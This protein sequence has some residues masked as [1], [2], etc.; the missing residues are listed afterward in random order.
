MPSECKNGLDEW[1]RITCFVSEAVPIKKRNKTRQK[2]LFYLP[3]NLLSREILIAA[4][5]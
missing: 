2:H 1:A 3:L 5:D 4:F